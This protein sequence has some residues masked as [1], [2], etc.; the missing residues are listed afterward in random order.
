[1]RTSS[2]RRIAYRIVLAV[3]LGLASLAHAQAPAAVPNVELVDLGEI[4][5]MVLQPHYGL[6]IAGNFTAIDGTSRSGLARIGANGVDASWNPNPTWLAPTPSIPRR[7]TVAPDGG[8]FV[9]GD[10][11]EIAGHGVGCIAKLKPGGELDTSWTAPTTNCDFEPVFDREGWM[12][13]IDSDDTVR[14]ARLDI[15]GSADPWWEYG[16]MQPQLKPYK[17]LMEFGNSLYVASRNNWGQMWLSRVGPTGLE[18]WSSDGLVDTVVAMEQ[19]EYGDLYVAYAGGAIQRFHASSGWPGT[20]LPISEP[21]TGLREMKLVDAGSTQLLYLA[22]DDGVRVVNAQSGQVMEHYDV[23]PGGFV[24]QLIPG[25]NIR[26]AGKF[27]RAGDGVSQSLA[28]VSER[29]MPGPQHAYEISAAG[30]VAEVVM[31]S[32][33]GA[34]VRGSFVKADRQTRNGIFR[35]TS[36]GQMDVNWVAAVDGAITQVAV[37]ASNDV[38]VAGDSLSLAG[39]PPQTYLAKLDGATGVP[40]SPHWSADSS[41]SYVASDIAVDAQDRLYVT[42]PQQQPFFGVRRILPTNGGELDSQWNAEVGMPITGVDVI[43]D[44][45]YLRS[46]GPQQ[47]SAVHRIGLQTNAPVDPDWQLNFSHPQYTPE[48]S[49]VKGDGL[50]NILVGGR[51]EVQMNSGLQS[52]LVRYPANAPSATADESWRPQLDGAVSSIAVDA[53]GEVFVAGDFRQVGGQANPGLVKLS[54][55]DASVRTDWAPAYGAQALCV[56]DAQRLFVAGGDWRNTLVALPL[57]V[58]ANGDAPGPGLD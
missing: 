27:Y 1:M 13:Y 40:V 22:A 21:L 39:G 43:G 34:I 42:A 47:G 53:L 30:S 35:L 2:I 36:A 31:Q 11:V 25:F 49:V 58:S 8:V 56:A 55:I 38:Y 3:P 32:N 18:R 19:S 15:G 12:Y 4:Q 20:T 50:G 54:P 45:V 51:F 26:A 46:T 16:T 9:S 28:F 24:N 10:L 48:L 5:S 29:G 41:F 37:N 23:N 14:R 57:T 33:G 44:H 52:H 6:L 17:L 7:V